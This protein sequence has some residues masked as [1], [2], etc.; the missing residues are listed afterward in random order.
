MYRELGSGYKCLV[1]ACLRCGAS[2]GD[3]GW[4]CPA[5][6]APLGDCPSCGEPVSAGDRFCGACG[7][8]RCQPLLD[9]AADLT[10]VQLRERT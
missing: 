1:V 8:L 10:A 9:G 5:C 7:R 4:F 2:G 6:D 3:G